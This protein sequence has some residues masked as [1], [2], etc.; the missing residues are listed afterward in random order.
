MPL[1]P[2]EAD[3]TNG[4]TLTAQPDGS[5]LASGPN[6]ELTTYTVTFDTTAARASPAC[7]SRRCPTRP[8]ARRSGP[9]RLRPLPRHRA[10]MSRRRRRLPMARDAAT[11]LAIKTIKVDDSADA[12]EPADLLRRIAGRRAARAARGPSTRC[13]IPSSACRATLCS[14]RRRRSASPAARAITL[15]IDQLDGTIGQGVGRFRL[16]AT[17]AADPLVGGEIP[18]AAA[19]RVLDAASRPSAAWRRQR[20]SPRSSARRLR[21]LEPTRDALAAAR[22]A[23]VDLQ[24]PSTLVMKERPGF[25]RP[26]YELRERGS[27]TSRGERSVRA[28]AAGAAA[29][30]RRACRPTGSAWRAGWSTRTTR[31]SRASRSTASGSS[32]SAAAWSRRAR[33]SGRRARRRRT[34]SCSTG[35]PSSSWT[36][37]GARRPCCGR[38]S[39]SAT[40]RQSS[41]VPPAL[42][43]ARS[44]QP[45]ARARAALPPRSRDG[46]RRVARRE[47]AAQPRRCTG[48]ACSRRSRRA[49]GT[50]P[51]TAT[52]G[53]R[54]RARIATAAAST[55]SG[56]GRR[57]IRAH[58]VRRDQPRVLHG[59]ARAH[60]H[61]AAGADAAERSGVVRGGAGAGATR[62]LREAGAGA[63]RRATASAF[64]ISWCCRAKPG[65]GRDRAAR[66]ALRRRAQQYQQRRPRRGRGR[67]RSPDR[68]G[69]PHA[70]LAAWTLVANVLLTSTKRSPR[71]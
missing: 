68:H 3:A 4:V 5:L 27:F 46:P 13:G 51:T 7:G 49:S 60:E 6:A 20:I 25:E 61:A 54:A 43:R 40:Y 15:R 57:R 11:P 17:T 26:S 37:A 42:A 56:G 22:K 64:A 48:R 58:D 65:A 16:A 67:C 34:P 69:R 28:D 1:A 55:R 52:S 44:V 71:Q 47:R 32:S 66:R 9:R 70:D 33:I 35:S 14:P 63:R 29:D 10:C 36:A 24:I 62:V 21:S 19:R 50:C 23:L 12:F 2:R 8:A 41:A 31:S 30:A 45:A 59:A 18:A 38:S 53:R 39:R